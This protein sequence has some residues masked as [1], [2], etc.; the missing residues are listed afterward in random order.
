MAGSWVDR[1]ADQPLLFHFLRKLPEWNYRATKARLRRIVAGRAPARIL[2]LGCG[3]GEF[4]GLFPADRYLGVDVHPGYVRLAR[5][6][7]PQHRFVCE[8]AIAWGG[9]GAGFDLTLVNGV[10]HHLDDA[11]ARALLAAAVR[12]TRSGGTLVVIEDAHVPAAG[13]LAGLVHALDHGHFIRTP[14]TWAAMVRE[15]MSIQES[16]T[17]QSGICPYH[18]MVGL[19]A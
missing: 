18:L 9:D 6:L 16:E 12:H 11:T 3:T 14:E 13:P 5:R 10:L 1:V 8:D 2:D 4:A 19:R 7:R 17:Y 15:F